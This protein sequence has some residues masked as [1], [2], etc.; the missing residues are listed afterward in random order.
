MAKLKEALETVVFD[1]A[2]VET[3]IIDKEKEHPLAYSQ[4]QMEGDEINWIGRLPEEKAK[5]II[6]LHKSIS[7]AAVK[8]RMALVKMAGA[9]LDSII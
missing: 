2:S 1:L 9:V 8:N 3:C 6:E 4:I 7:I 5:D